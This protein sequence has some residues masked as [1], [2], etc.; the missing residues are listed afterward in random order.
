MRKLVD[1]CKTCSC[2]LYHAFNNFSLV[3]LFRNGSRLRLIGV[4]V[5]LYGSLAT[6]SCMLYDNGWM[7]TFFHSLHKSRD[8][9]GKSH[10]T[11]V[12]QHTASKNISYN[13]CC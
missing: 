1:L 13:L 9:L 10:E 6:M 5:K 7:C 4:E 8:I 2:M 11:E 3:F 12:I